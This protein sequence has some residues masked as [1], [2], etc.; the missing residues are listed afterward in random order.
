MTAQPAPRIFSTVFGLLMVASSAAPADGPALLAAVVGAVAVL[1]ALV[2]RPAATAAVLAT[3]AALALSE[4]APLY[5]ALSG[6]SA[7]V[8]LVIHH[9]VGAPAVVTTTR[10]TVLAALGFTVVGLVAISVP[11]QVRWLPLLAPLVVAGIYVLVIRP[12]LE[13]SRWEAARPG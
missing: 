11:V 4:P 7:A 3:V 6:L 1:A 9:A 5:A 8:Y 13:N 2:V 12:F 10:A